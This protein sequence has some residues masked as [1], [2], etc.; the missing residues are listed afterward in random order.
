MKQWLIA[1][2]VVSGLAWTAAQAETYHVGAGQ[3]TRSLKQ[4]IGQLKPGDIVEV[5]PGTYK[6]NMKITVSGTKDA[7]I[8]IK[9]VAGSPRPVF[10]AT[11]Q[12]SSG[13]GQIPRGVFQ[14]EGGY[15][16]LGHLE[17]T[18]ARNSGQGDGVRMNGSPYAIVRDCKIHHNDNGCFSNDSGETFIE[19]CEVYANGSDAF[20]GFSHNFYMHSKHLVVRGCYIH[21]S[22]TGQNLKTRS[23]Y[24]ELWYNWISDSDDGEIGMVEEKG[25]TDLPNSNALMVGNIV[26]SSAK[27]PPKANGSRF[28][29]FASESKTPHD[30]TLYMFYNTFI[31]GAPK[32]ASITLRD[33][34]ARLVCSNN[35]LVGS[36]SVV[37]MVAGASVSGSHNFV[38]ADAK[39]PAEFTSTITG[40]SAGFMDLVKR[41]FRLKNDSPCVGKGAGDLDYVDGDGR[42]HTLAATRSYVPPLKLITRTPKA[43]ADLGA[44]ESPASGSPTDSFDIVTP[45]T[46][47]VAADPASSGSPA[48]PATPAVANPTTPTPAT[49]D[50]PKPAPSPSPSPVI[51]PPL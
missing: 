11:G 18:G 29:E 32:H 49:P 19:R 16:V 23:H 10:D 31:S 24:N 40:G 42:K 21:D 2:M 45:A 34:K 41:D 39:V 4:I 28:L 37:L 20:A 22:H 13:R 17:I 30:G 1:A 44:F 51:L 36:D 12:E 14:I 15:I 5:A 50:T 46:P 35:I 47:A 43:A 26:V 9:G 27:R 6:E 3:A 38:G 25:L 33:K 8:I 48:T 7:P